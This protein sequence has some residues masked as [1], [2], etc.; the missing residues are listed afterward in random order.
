MLT[1]EIRDR[2]VRLHESAVNFPV[3]FSTL[4]GLVQ[5]NENILES[6]LGIADGGQSVA[7]YGGQ[8]LSQLNSTT[9]VTS[10]T[11]TLKL[12]RELD[13]LNKI[14]ALA[15]AEFGEPDYFKGI[16]ERIEGF[17]DLY[18]AYIS[19]PTGRYAARLISLAPIFL[20]ALNDFFNVSNLI[21]VSLIQTLPDT[22]EDEVFSLLLPGEF[23]LF[24]F[25]NR[26]QAIL[27]I[28]TELAQLLDISMS[29]TPLRIAK[30]ESGSLWM[31]LIGDAKIFKLVDDLVRAAG[32]FIYRNYTNEGKLSAIPTRIEALD[33]LA[34]LTSKLQS[35]G[36]PTDEMEESLQKCGQQIAKNLNSLLENQTSVTINHQFIPLQ[37][38]QAST[39]LEANRVLRIGS[40][41]ARV[42]PYIE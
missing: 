27:N 11:S 6:M 29:A 16:I 38:A 36:V 22:A 39:L 31:V 33:S 20:S 4:E 17:S 25:I 19:N 5:A 1:S 7:S 12:Y 15:A 8:I 30:I 21:A 26:L 2:F 13:S 37:H 42:E 35:M 32:A 18:D 10:K 23:L 40:D 9:S 41:P 24:D 34:Q 3:L 14:I 28:Y